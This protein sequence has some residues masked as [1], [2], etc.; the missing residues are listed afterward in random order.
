MPLIDV[1][2]AFSNNFVYSLKLHVGFLLTCTSQTRF[3]YFCSILNLYFIL[4]M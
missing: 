1:Y 3:S 4:A 2:Y